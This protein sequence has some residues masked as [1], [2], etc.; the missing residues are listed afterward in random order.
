MMDVGA[1]GQRRVEV[2]SMSDPELLQSLAQQ[3]GTPLIVVD[4]DVLRRNYREFRSCLPRVQPYYAVKANPDPPIIRTFFGLGSSFDVAS[5]EEFLTVHKN[6]AGLPQAERQQFIWGR[7]IYANP[8]KA[9]PTLRELDPYKPLVTYD[10]LEEVRKLARHAPQAG[11]VLRLQVLSTGAVVELSSKFGAPAAEAV[12]LLDAAR[13]AGLGVEGLSFHV[14]SQNTNVANY[15][16]ALHLV[17]EILQEARL[18]G[19]DQL[20]VVDIG[21]GFPAPYNDSVVPFSELARL[22]AEELERLF[23]PELEIVAEPGRFLVATAA[24]AVCT[25]IGKADRDGRR[26]YYLDDGVYQ[27]FSGIVFDRCQY[28]LEA[29]KG[30]E[31]MLC[32]VYGPTCDALDTISLS[33]SLPDLDVGD[34]VYSRNIGAYSYATATR[35]NGFAPAKVVHVNIAEREAAQ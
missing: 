24:T 20:K 11:L 21:G 28:H 2:T 8:I 22:I 32:A 23:P 15:I 6:I 34:L 4:H 35:F 25:V 27:T 1:A 3:H 19:Y 5:M 13:D 7:V 26:R 33:E 17:A 29:F 31:Q 9:I 18:H 10:N 14:G 16:D 30:G 12:G